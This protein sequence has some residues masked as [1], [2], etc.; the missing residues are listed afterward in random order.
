MES[1]HAKL[2]CH[3][4]IHPTL[5]SPCNKLFPNNFQNN[6]DDIEPKAQ[7]NWRISVPGYVL[8]W[9]FQSRLLTI[10]TNLQ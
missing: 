4:S 2:N 7:P 3:P 6:F 1:C 8:C 10:S 9:Q 5:N